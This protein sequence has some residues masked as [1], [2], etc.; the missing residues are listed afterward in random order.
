MESKLQVERPSSLLQNDVIQ[1][2]EKVQREDQ[3]NG[4]IAKL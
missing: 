4:K 3:E 1:C 2:I